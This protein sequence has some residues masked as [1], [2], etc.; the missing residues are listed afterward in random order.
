M[1]VSVEVPTATADLLGTSQVANNHLMH[2]QML[3]FMGGAFLSLN[4][5]VLFI[6]GLLMDRLKP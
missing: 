1:N 4:G 5:S 2:L 6:G 3:G